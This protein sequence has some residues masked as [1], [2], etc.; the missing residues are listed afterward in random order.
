MPDSLGNLGEL[1]AFYAVVAAVGLVAIMVL[2][3]VR[4]RRW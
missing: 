1:I 2:D 4:R 3:R